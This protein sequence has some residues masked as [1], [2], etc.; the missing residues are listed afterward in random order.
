MLLGC[1]SIAAADKSRD[2]GH[3]HTHAQE[4]AR[5]GR[6]F[7]NREGRDLGAKGR[8]LWANHAAKGG[9]RDEGSFGGSG[10]T[11]LL[12]RGRTS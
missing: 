5:L 7:Y 9:Q 3:A 12:H 4:G 6:P 8:Q 1:G 10:Y 11:L 2:A